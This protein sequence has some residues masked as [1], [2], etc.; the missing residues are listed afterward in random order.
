[1]SRASCLAAVIVALL[2][3]TS[4]PV[5]AWPAVPRFLPSDHGLTTETL[6]DATTDDFPGNFAVV[7]LMRWV[8]QPSPRPLIVPP[9]GGPVFVVVERGLVTATQ[10]GVETRLAAGEMFAPNDYERELILHVGGRDEAILFVATF[11]TPGFLPCDWGHDPLSYNRQELIQTP[12]D[13]L[14]GG[15]GRLRLERLT[16]PPRSALPPQEASPL[17]WTSVGEGVLELTLEGQM[18]YFWEPGEERTFRRG[19]PWPQIP[20]SIANPLLNGGT[21]MTLRNAGDDPLVLYRLTLTPSAGTIAPPGSPLGG[22][23]LY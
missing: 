2:L 18:P 1:M 17:I 11:K 19:Q 5:G 13:A 21:R 15:S 9:H 6:L 20:D 3:S 14:P 12:V 23:P 16:L 22:S 8:L 10:Q 7:G 4:A